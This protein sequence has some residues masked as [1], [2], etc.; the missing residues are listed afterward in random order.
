VT[1]FALS[2][3]EKAAAWQWA[4]WLAQPA[5]MARWSALNATWPAYAEAIPPPFA[6]AESAFPPVSPATDFILDEWAF[7]LRA[8][9]GGEAAATRLPLLQERVNRIRQ[10][11]MLE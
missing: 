8:I 4:A 6:Q 3:A 1:L 10:A 2:E 9:W 5:Q 11:F 7:A